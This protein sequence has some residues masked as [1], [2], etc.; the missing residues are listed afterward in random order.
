M[1]AHV[2][3][4][5]ADRVAEIE[6]HRPDKKNALTGA[7]YDAM[8]DAIL[9]A[10]ADPGVHAVLLH[11]QADCFT[12][13][14]DLADFVAAGQAG[15]AGHVP[16]PATRFLG[17]IRTAPKPLVA[18]VGGVAV[19][20]GTTMLLHCDLVYA[21]PNARF[22][23]P[24]VPLGLAPEGGS[25]LLLPML[26]GHQR[27]S[28]MLLLGRPFGAEKALAAG[29]VNEVVPA[30]R[31]IAH[32]REA[33]LAVAALPPESVRITKEWLK[34]PHALALEERMAEEIRVF[35]ERLSSPEAKAAMAAFFARRKA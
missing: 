28:E 20:I 9:R 2:K 8:S 11:G 19:G 29:L 21:A 27:A 14:N 16:T 12:S 33:A 13:G 1:T 34:R 23:M 17:V 30:D 35:G 15:G 26:A 6:I 4:R 5:T 7:M 22:Q 25:S 24:F 3:T 18:A 32:A 31:L 10:E